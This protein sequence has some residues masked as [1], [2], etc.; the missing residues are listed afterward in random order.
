MLTPLYLAL[1][2]G[3]EFHGISPSGASYW[4][5]TAKIDATDESGKETP[6]FIKVMVHRLGQGRS[7]AEGESQIS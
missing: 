7:V 2:A 3:T 5:R 1:P 4:A 6:F